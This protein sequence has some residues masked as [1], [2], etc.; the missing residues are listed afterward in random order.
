MNDNEN[1]MLAQAREGSTGMELGHTLAP[2]RRWQEHCIK[3][4]QQDSRAVRHGEDVGV[5]YV[6]P[7]ARSNQGREP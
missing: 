2:S 5:G 3:T 4:L 7:N 6:S 1:I